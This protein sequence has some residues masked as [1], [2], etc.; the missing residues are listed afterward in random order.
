MPERAKP[1]SEEARLLGPLSKRRE[2]NLRWR[3]FDAAWDKVLPPL[4]VVVHTQSAKWETLGTSTSRDDIA[5]AGIR[6][7]GLQDAGVMEELVEMAGPAFKTA[8]PTRRQRQTL[9]E[10]GV[11]PP[12]PPPKG[13]LPKFIRRQ[14]GLL[15]SRIPV[16]RYLRRTGE[17]VPPGANGKYEVSLVPN[18]LVRAMRHHRERL[19]QADEVDLAWI[20]A[21]NTKATKARDHR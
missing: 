15:L 10:R 9:V 12:L 4:Q 21:A 13:P 11:E 16:L 19:P 5:K 17:G 20:E 7:V 8:M 2:V 14:Y 18:A 3:F 6:P 1:N